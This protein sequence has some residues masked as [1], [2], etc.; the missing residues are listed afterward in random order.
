MPNYTEKHLI[1][2]PAIQL[3]AYELGWNSVNAYDAPLR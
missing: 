3:M 1:E 2:Q